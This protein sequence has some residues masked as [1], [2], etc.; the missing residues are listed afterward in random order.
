MRFHAYGQQKILSMSVKK[1]KHFVDV[2]FS[3]KLGSL[4]TVLLLFLNNS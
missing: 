4:V 1:V 3:L 2:L